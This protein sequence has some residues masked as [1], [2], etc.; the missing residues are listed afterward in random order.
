MIRLLNY[1]VLV[2]CALVA[3]VAIGSPSLQQ[4]GS[5]PGPQLDNGQGRAVLPDPALTPGDTL[6]VTTADI[7]VPGYSAKVRNVPASVKRGLYT[8]YHVV[9]KPGEHFEVDHLISLELGG[10]NSTRN[11]WPEPYQGNSNAHDKD[12][13]EN[14]LHADVCTNTMPLSQAQ[15]AI[16]AN[17]IAAYHQY[18]EDTP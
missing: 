17:W 11:L 5:P 18:V 7:C 1:A 6:A 14:R 10:S 2:M 13:L 8:A 12:R 3:A 9:P 15:R 16:A 4:I